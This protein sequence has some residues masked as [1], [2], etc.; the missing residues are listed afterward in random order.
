MAEFSKLII[1]GRG[2]AL[3]AKTIAGTGNIEFAKI[4]TSSAVYNLEQVE[5]LTELANVEQT[6]LISSITRTNETAVKIETSFNNLEL[7]SGYYMRSLGLYAVDPDEGE[8]LYAVTTEVSGNCYMPAYNDVTVSGAYVKLITTVGNAEHVSLEVNAA[9]TATVGNIREL[10]DNLDTVEIRFDETEVTERENIQSQDTLGTM[11]KKIK[12]WFSDLKAGAF[13]S[14]VNNCTTTEEGTVLDG[15]QGK[16]LQD[17]IMELQEADNEIN[18][19]I[20]SLGESVADGKALIASAITNK[21]I[22]TPADATFATMAGNIG[23]TGKMIY[24]GTGTS[25]NVA[26]IEGFR[27]FNVNNFLVCYNGIQ[28]SFSSE[29][30]NE[31]YSSNKIINAGFGVSGG[32]IN[33]NYN[34]SNGAFSIS[35]NVTFSKYHTYYGGSRNNSTES[36]DIIGIKVYL[37]TGAM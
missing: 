28:N 17:Q 1:T 25:Y 37:Y 29:N 35:K 22:N 4:S 10:K 16:V 18:S 33:K 7:K 30:M 36:R 31:N 15:R 34:P 12:K 19:N 3:I 26:H 23:K 27:N 32:G 5:G 6:S 11:F 2:Q 20:Q 24:L 13:A 8:I 9:A 14:I 21:G